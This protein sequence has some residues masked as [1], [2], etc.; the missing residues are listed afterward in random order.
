[1]YGEAAHVEREYGIYLS[2]ASPGSLPALISMNRGEELTVGAASTTEDLHTVRTRLVE[3]ESGFAMRHYVSPCFLLG[4]VAHGIDLTREEREA[5]HEA[6]AATRPAGGK[7]CTERRR[8]DAEALWSRSLLGDAPDS[9][10]DALSEHSHGIIRSPHEP[11][12]RLSDVIVRRSALRFQPHRHPRVR[13]D[14]SIQIEF[15]GISG[16]GEVAG[17][18]PP[19]ELQELCSSVEG[20]SVVAEGDTLSVPVGGSIQGHG[21]RNP[22]AEGS[23]SRLRPCVHTPR[24]STAISSR[25]T[26]RCRL[27]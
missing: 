13:L 8:E 21:L 11:V 26:L 16:T 6:L 18:T 2:P 4:S 23:Q 9:K 3:L 5:L 27:W 12:E 10:A 24:D 20:E 25:R 17:H 7:H 22:G 19:A 14:H 15:R 1:V